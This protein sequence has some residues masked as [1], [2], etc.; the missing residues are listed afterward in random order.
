M[1]SALAEAALELKSVAGLGDR[2]NIELKMLG[3]IVLGHLGV[4]SS[5]RSR[6]IQPVRRN[7]CGGVPASHFGIRA[8]RRVAAC[9]GT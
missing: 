4:A 8:A 1:E 7:M 5:S 2:D 9:I 3:R 6:R